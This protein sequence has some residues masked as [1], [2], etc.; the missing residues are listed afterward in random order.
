MRSDYQTRSLHYFHAFAVRD[1]LNL[2]NVDDSPSAPDQ[3]SIDLESL[4]PSKADEKE[5]SS[6]NM[7][8]LIARI[9]KKHIPYFAKYGKGIE[10]HIKHQFYAEMS[11][12][13]EVVSKKFCISKYYE[14]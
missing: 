12:K 10:K 3:S 9:L 7:G 6:N 2:D 8:I 1:R 11:R 14:L 13:S 5:I 4:F